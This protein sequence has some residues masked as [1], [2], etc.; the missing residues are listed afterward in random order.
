MSP[1]SPSPFEA[2]KL[3]GSSPKPEQK[4]V[5]GKRSRGKTGKRGKRGKRGKS[6]RKTAK[7]GTKRKS[8]VARLFRL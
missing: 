7:K 8:F 4:Q 6:A 3:G 5:G 2:K 1:I